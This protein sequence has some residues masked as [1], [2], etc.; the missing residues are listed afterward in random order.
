M[1]MKIQ[2]K[3]FELIE[4]KIATVPDGYYLKSIYEYKLMEPNWSNLIWDI[5]E[6]QEEAEAAITEHMK[7]YEKY[8]IHKIY[9]SN[10]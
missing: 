5:F 10:T 9:T 7:P 8:V 4:T 6:T 2:Y 3:I 1:N